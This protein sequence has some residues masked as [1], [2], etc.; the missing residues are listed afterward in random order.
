MQIWSWKVSQH[1]KHK[2]EGISSH[3]RRQTMRRTGTSPERKISADCRGWC[4][5][6]PSPTS[7]LI[8]SIVHPA[9][10]STHAKKIFLEA[11]PDTKDPIPQIRPSFRTTDGSNKADRHLANSHS[12]I[13]CQPDKRWSKNGVSLSAGMSEEHNTAATQKNKGVILAFLFITWLLIFL[14][15]TIFV[16]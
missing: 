8:H 12:S 7:R 14:C 2:G 10:L 9:C 4:S 3:R 11:R 13:S 15:Q 6:P 5:F 1:C 16:L